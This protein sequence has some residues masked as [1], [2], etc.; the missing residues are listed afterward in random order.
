LRTDHIYFSDGIKIIDCIEFNDRFRYTD[1]TADLAFLAMNLDFE[2]FSQ[3]AQEPMNTYLEY[4]KDEE[5]MILLDFYSKRISNRWV[6]CKSHQ[7]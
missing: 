1:T 3:S 7:G 2:E 5:M 4:T 6:N